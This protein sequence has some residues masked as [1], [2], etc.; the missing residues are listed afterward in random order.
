M[1]ATTKQLGRRLSVKSKKLKQLNGFNL[2]H[3]KLAEVFGGGSTGDGDQP[4]Q[5]RILSADHC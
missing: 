3:E 2:P 5:M 1:K 4:K